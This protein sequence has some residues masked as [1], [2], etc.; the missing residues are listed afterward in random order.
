[1][2][3]A[4]DAVPVYVLSDATGISGESMANALLLQ[5]PE[6]SFER[7]LIP[8]ISSV[9]EAQRVVEQLDAEA[10][11]PSEPLVFMTVMRDDV[12]EALLTARTPIIDFVGTHL[13][14]LEERLGVAGDHAPSRLHG[15]G[16]TNRYNRRMQAVEFAIEHDDGQ[17]MRALDKADVV[18]VAP[19]RCGKTPT[20]MFMALQYGLFVA[21]YPL[22]D[23]DL[24]TDELP[25]PVRHLRKRCFGLLTSPERLHQVRTERRP[26]SRYASLAQ[27]R[28]ELSRARQI[29]LAQQLS[30]VDSSTKSV[31]E[32]STIILQKLPVATRR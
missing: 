24:D 32:M 29:F 15:V 19:S 26:D 6:V 27:T 30:F 9:Q 4:D 20:S 25:R 18:L 5:F 8:F 1:M 12:R 3:A 16:D 11:G 31:E 7:H 13:P 21:N 14:Q 28:W 10:V 17:S 2:A 23:E 22:V